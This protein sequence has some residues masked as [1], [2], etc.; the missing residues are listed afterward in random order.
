MPY[1]PMA[2]LLH[3]WKVASFDSLPIFPTPISD[4]HQS[5]LYM[6]ELVGFIFVFRL[7]VSLISSIALPGLGYTYKSIG[8]LQAC[9]LLL[10]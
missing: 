5:F 7:F 1:T 6:H 9:F 2:Y 8:K 3:N 4:D 10:L